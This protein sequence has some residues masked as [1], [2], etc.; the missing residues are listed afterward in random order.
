MNE[1]LSEVHRLRHTNAN[2]A[3]NG[4]NGNNGN[5]SSSSDNSSNSNNSDGNSNSNNNILSHVDTPYSDL[6]TRLLSENIPL[7]ADSNAVLELLV[8]RLS[9][10]E[11]RA[12]ELCKGTD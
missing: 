1:I 6:A 9:R 2:N 10:D 7:H 3:N 4:N 5:D 11:T 8:A 12:T